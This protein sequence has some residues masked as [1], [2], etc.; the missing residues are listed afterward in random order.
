MF[1]AGTRPTWRTRPCRRKTGVYR[2]GPLVLAIGEDLAPLPASDLAVP[3]GSDA[4]AV[5][6]G[7]KPV[8]LT[9]DPS[10][11]PRFSLQFTAPVSGSPTGA[12]SVRFP[13]CG[14]RRGGAASVHRFMGGFT[15]QGTGCVRLTVTPAGGPA[16]TMLIPVGDTLC[17]CPTRPAPGALPDRAM[18]YLGV[19]CPVGNS[20][21]CDRVG[22]AV[23]FARPAR[24]VTVQ[25]A[26]R[27]VAL[28]P[29]AGRF[30]GLQLLAGLPVPGRA[31]APRTA[32]RA[33]PRR[34]DR[35]GRRAGGGAVR[36]PHR[37]PARRHGG[38][39][40]R[41]RLPPCRLRLTRSARATGDAVI[42]RTWP[43]R[44]E[45][46][47]AVFE[48]GVKRGAALG[49]QRLYER[50][51]PD[52]QDRPSNSCGPAL[53]KLGH[54]TARRRSSGTAD[55]G[56]HRNSSG[57]ISSIGLLK[58]SRLRGRSLSSVATQSRSVSLCTDRSV[59]FGKY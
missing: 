38:H 42:R 33:R 59:P 23:T 39:A 6:S 7:Q 27:T 32:A 9:V 46:Q 25:L 30:A 37:V 3:T 29:A 12:Y 17:G 35:L 57:P 50:P 15:V 53:E 48:L 10:S 16:S 4:I 56:G 18:P 14:A 58:P 5:V 52:A 55:S 26:G 31:A 11:V 2:A 40:L 34:P 47:S 8:R 22:I 19:S 28:T 43:S 51:E 21:A 24:L 36:P 13:A 1:R 44:L 49:R 20:I 41:P 54:A 45:L